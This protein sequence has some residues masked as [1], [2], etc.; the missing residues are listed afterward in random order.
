MASNDVGKTVLVYNESGRRCY[1]SPFNVLQVWMK[2][3][4]DMLKLETFNCKMKR[5][6]ADGLK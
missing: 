5:W 2:Q 6:S 4:Q 1:L 3:S